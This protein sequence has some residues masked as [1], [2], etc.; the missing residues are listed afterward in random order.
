M[1]YQC[2]CSKSKGW[3]ESAVELKYYNLKQEKIFKLKSNRQ[4]NMLT[5]F[6]TAWKAC[7]IGWEEAPKANHQCLASALCP[8]LLPQGSSKQGDSDWMGEA[9]PALDLC[10]FLSQALHCCS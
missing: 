6:I 1:K 5:I 3:A 9:V 10:P 8:P 2:N 7:R 4:D